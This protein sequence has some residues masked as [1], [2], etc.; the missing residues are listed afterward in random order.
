MLNS[1]SKYKKVYYYLS[2]ILS[3]INIVKGVGPVLQIAEGHTIE[4]P[5]DVRSILD[6][7]TNLTWPTTWF[8]PRLTGHAIVTDRSTIRYY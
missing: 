7:R 4:L 6:E 3:R 2:I 1:K 5:E 8:V